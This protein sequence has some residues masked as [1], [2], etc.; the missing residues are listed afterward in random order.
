MQTDGNELKKKRF[1]NVLWIVLL[2]AG[3]LL[4][5]L[6]IVI[7]NVFTP[8]FNLPLFSLSQLC[9]ELLLIL[10]LAAW[11]V[12]KG[13]TKSTNIFRALTP[14][15]IVLASSLFLMTIG[16]LSV[17]AAALLLIGM[18]GFH[19]AIVLAIVRGVLNYKM[20]QSSPPESAQKTVAP[21]ANSHSIFSVRNTPTAAAPAADAVK[22]YTPPY[23]ANI[24]SR[25]IA[26][27]PLPPLPQQRKLPPKPAIVH[28]ET[29]G[30]EM[31]NDG[32]VS[33]IGDRYFCERC[34]ERLLLD[35][36]E[37]TG[38]DRKGQIVLLIRELKRLAEYKQRKDLGR[39]IV[40][41]LSNLESYRIFR[42]KC[43]DTRCECCGRKL[44]NDELIIFNDMML[45]RECI[46]KFK[47]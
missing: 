39:K 40:T 8:E 33:H 28:C 23:S 11:R 26:P 25:R 38:E 7:S 45:C 36:Y 15:Q 12:S 1:I 34:Y 21:S 10:A 35:Y 42:E 16:M 3:L 22:P 19:V 43:L 17:H 5:P 24:V 30:I 37:K 2:V 44:S 18:L 47:K 27:Q 41:A 31:K 32:S 14:A 9:G 13:K 6:S 29:C 4:I 46:E 20:K